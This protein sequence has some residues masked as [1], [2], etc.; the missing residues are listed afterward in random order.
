MS[1]DVLRARMPQLLQ[2][3]SV[4]RDMADDGT[5]EVSFALMD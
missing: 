5:R 3:M 1:R 4:V 2:V